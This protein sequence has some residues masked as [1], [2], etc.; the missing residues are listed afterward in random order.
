MYSVAFSVVVYASKE[1]NV[2]YKPQFME[3]LAQSYVEPSINRLLNSMLVISLSPLHS[4]NKRPPSRLVLTPSISLPIPMPSPHHPPAPPVVP[5]PMPIHRTWRD[6][7][8]A[9]SCPGPC[10]R[11]QCPACQSGAGFDGA[12]HSP[13]RGRAGG[14]RDRGCGAHIPTIAVNVPLGMPF[15]KYYQNLGFFPSLL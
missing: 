15:G 5:K 4:L 10:T 2:V 8:R 6:I 3:A 13:V 14:Q 7:A 12:D 11:S 9:V 1:A